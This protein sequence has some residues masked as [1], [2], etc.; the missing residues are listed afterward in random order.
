MGAN[1]DLLEEHKY[2][3]KY[4]LEEI[5]DILNTKRKIKI[6]EVKTK[7]A[8]KQFIGIYLLIHY[9]FKVYNYE[10]LDLYKFL[11][12]YLYVNCKELQKWRIYDSLGHYVSRGVEEYNM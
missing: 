6:T 11:E 12:P 10:F 1:F 4:R 9:D 8:Y 2:K 5:M 3:N 7:L